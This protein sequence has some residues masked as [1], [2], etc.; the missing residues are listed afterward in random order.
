MPTCNTFHQQAKHHIY[1]PLHI[2]TKTTCNRKRGGFSVARRQ[3]V[4]HRVTGE[5]YSD[6]IE[7]YDIG[8]LYTWL[9]NKPII[10]ALYYNL[11]IWICILYFK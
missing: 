1:A 11:L 9:K 7:L 4:A 8:L 6:I 10:N 5:T 2:N 3:K